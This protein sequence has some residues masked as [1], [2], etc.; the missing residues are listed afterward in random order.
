MLGICPGTK[1]SKP[2]K[3]ISVLDAMAFS[4]QFHTIIYGFSAYP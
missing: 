1:V 3:I 2:W 4:R